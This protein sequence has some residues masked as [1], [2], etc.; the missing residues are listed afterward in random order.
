MAA[1]RTRVRASENGESKFA[2]HIEMGAHQILG[3]E[4]PSVGGGGLGPNPFDLLCAAL[5]ECT[6][7]TVRWFA[8]ERGWPLD[9]VEVVVDHVRKQPAG[10]SR[11]ADMFDT[12]VFL[13]GAG[14]DDAQRE[15]LM[16]VAGNCPIHRLLLGTPVITT[17]AGTPLAEVLDG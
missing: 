3:D 10:A 8:D 11:A 14:L 16:A 13:K 9:H 6:A 2:V 7:M 12:T 5:A 1:P 17:R 15:R 4:P